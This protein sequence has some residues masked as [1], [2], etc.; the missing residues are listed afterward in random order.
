MFLQQCSTHKI[1]HVSAST[2]HFRSPPRQRPVVV[3][4]M[5]PNRTISISVSTSRDQI[6]DRDHL[7]NA[8]TAAVDPEFSCVGC[9]AQ[10]KSVAALRTSARSVF[11]NHSLLANFHDPVST[12]GSSPTR[13]SRFCNSRGVFSMRSL[14]SCIAICI[15]VTSYE[16]LELQTAPSTMQSYLLH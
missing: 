3:A 7:T 6:T 4:I 9:Q 15:K 14:P 16:A 10:Q 11:I 8:E 12:F 1:I 5:G 13:P 2:V